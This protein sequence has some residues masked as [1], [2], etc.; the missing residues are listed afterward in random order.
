MG[1]IGVCPFVSKA[2]NQCLLRDWAFDLVGDL[3]EGELEQVFLVLFRVRPT[4][5]DR[6]GNRDFAPV[7]SDKF[8]VKN[9]LRQR[10]RL[11]E[12][13]RTTFQVTSRIVAFS[14]PSS[15]AALCLAASCAT[16]LNSSITGN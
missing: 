9:R 11:V 16:Q 14:E 3:A 7:F 8:P 2:Q 5:Q 1:S 15:L 6:F 12:R 13:A 4:C 10:P